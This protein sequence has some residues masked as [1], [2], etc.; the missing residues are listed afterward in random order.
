LNNL[1][2]AHKLRIGEKPYDGKQDAIA[3]GR[4][5]CMTYCQVCHPPDGSG[6]MGA[7]LIGGKHKHERFTPDLSLFKVVFG[8]ASGA[9][10]LFPKR[11]MQ[12]GDPES[13]GLRV[14]M[15]KS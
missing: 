11:I 12:G 1:R 6:R 8:G 13:D 2:S 4:K 14:H 5:R 7:S 3:D 9:M 10:Q 15:M